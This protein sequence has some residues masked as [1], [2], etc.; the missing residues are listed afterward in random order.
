MTEC[1]AFMDR[2]SFASAAVAAACLIKKVDLP[3]GGPPFKFTAL[4]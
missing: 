4:A 3:I 1:R 2:W